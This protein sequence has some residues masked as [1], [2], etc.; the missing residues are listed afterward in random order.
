MSNI[1]H[2]LFTCPMCGKSVSMKVDH[3]N[4]ELQEVVGF[5]KD[6]QLNISAQVKVQ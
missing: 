5:C 4:K 2:R 1:M 3:D 6:C